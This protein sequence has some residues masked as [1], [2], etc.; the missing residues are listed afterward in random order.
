MSRKRTSVEKQLAIFN[1]RRR[2]G[3]IER[4]AEMTG[5][6]ASHVS[7]VVNGLRN[8][9]QISY[10]AYTISKRR[11]TNAELAI[12]SEIEIDGYSPSNVYRAS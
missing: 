2:R 12:D 1:N 10:T 11:L 8:N 4:I 7:R 3:D 9:N 5:F 6:S